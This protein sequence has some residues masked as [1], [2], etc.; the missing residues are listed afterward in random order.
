MK[1]EFRIGKAAR[2]ALRFES[3]QCGI[4][5]EQAESGRDHTVRLGSISAG[6]EAESDLSQ[7]HR[8]ALEHIDAQA[9]IEI[10][11]GRIPALCEIE[12]NE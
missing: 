2:S 6:A 3:G 5:R 11:D 1:M 7:G 10:G 8:R 4:A 12:L 9:F